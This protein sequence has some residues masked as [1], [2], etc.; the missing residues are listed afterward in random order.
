NKGDTFLSMAV[1]LITGSPAFGKSSVLFVTWD[2]GEGS[3]SDGPIGF[4][5]VGATVKG[6]GYASSIQYD[7]SSTLRSLAESFGL[8]PLPGAQTATD[9]R[10]LFTTFP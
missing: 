8:A 1:P 4:I 2:E 6:G 5:A 10:D 9:L 3:S 7:H